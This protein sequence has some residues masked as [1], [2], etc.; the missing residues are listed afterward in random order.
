LV[1]FSEDLKQM[2]KYDTK[3]YQHA[4]FISSIYGTTTEVNRNMR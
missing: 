3:L 1:D 2:N 4:L